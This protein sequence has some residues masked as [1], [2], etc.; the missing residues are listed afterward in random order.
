M[1]NRFCGENTRL[2]A[3]TI[4]Y[5]KINQ[6]PCIILLADFEKAFDSINWSFFSN[7]VLSVL[8]LVPP[9]RHG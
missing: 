2:I 3:D 9:F 6:K 7:L 1:A 8:D 5:C 4:E